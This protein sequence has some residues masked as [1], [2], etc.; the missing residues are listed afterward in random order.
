LYCQLFE[1]VR[2]S[3]IFLVDSTGVILT[4]NHGAERLFGYSP[5]EA[6]GKNWE[7]LF[8][9]GDESPNGLLNRD[10]EGTVSRERQLLRSTGARVWSTL[11]LTPLPQL[12]ETDRVLGYSVVVESSQQQMA[13]YYALPAQGQIEG[14]DAILQELSDLKH[15]LA[16]STIVAITDSKGLI[17]YANDAFCRISQYS[18]QELLGQ[19][20]RIINAGHH[21]KPFFLSLW[22]TISSGK[23]WKGEIKNRAKDGSYYWVKTTIVPFLDN[24]GK[25]YQYVA[26]RHDITDRKRVEDEIRQLNEELEVRV[27]QRTLELEKKN[28]ELAETLAQLRES[29][30]LRSTFVSALTH[31]L[32]TP[33]VAQTRALEL[34]QSFQDQLP[35]RLAGLAERLIKSNDS[36]LDMVNKLLDTYQY[37][38]GKIQIFYEA[39]D[40]AQL[41]SDCLAELQP[42]AEKKNIALVNAVHSA[43][44]PLVAD[45]QQLRRVFV[46]LVG[47]AIENIPA[48]STIRI[49]PVSCEPDQVAVRVCDNGT[50][51]PP[52]ILPRLFDRY[53]TGHRT[54]KKIGSGLGLYIS[55]MILE[56]HGGTIQV[57]SEV[58]VGTCFTLT[59][60]RQPEG[61]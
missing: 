12:S 14:L 43:I 31:D 50:G 25:P 41:T 29:E 44:G 20:H 6:I 24:S 10:S 60:P 9:P 56:L 1:K 33:L 11:T 37:E 36:L 23:V 40:L 49:E 34:F 39:V 28:E 42:L 16:V 38:A 27:H 15:A 4:W 3:A 59:L 57:E 58:N 17:T 47:N 30:Q 45:G 54:R 46:N 18:R 8:P 2:D 52:E 55:R 22:R 19:D 51:I 21:P 53:F 7:I 26:I 48:G 32:R 35:D 5:A 61:D 13:E